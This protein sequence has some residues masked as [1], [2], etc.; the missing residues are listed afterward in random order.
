M[1]AS[2]DI[3]AIALILGC[4][5][6]SHIE[7]VSHHRQ[8]AEG[9]AFVIRRSGVKTSAHGLMMWLWVYCES[10]R[11]Q[12]CMMNF[13][14]QGQRQQMRDASQRECLKQRHIRPPWAGENSIAKHGRVRAV[15]VRD[16]W[17]HLL[18]ER[19]WFQW[20][21]TL[22]QRLTLLLELTNITLAWP[23]RISSVPAYMT[24]KRTWKK[25]RWI[26]GFIGWYSSFLS[27]RDINKSQEL[28]CF[29]FCLRWHINT[30][31]P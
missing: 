13:K 30:Q 24:H 3:F 12:V 21:W 6:L 17:T 5:S 11:C 26:L 7:V 4:C 23:R 16:C 2:V 9:I 1:L 31:L 29:T 27:Q 15:P 10:L 19:H 18:Q 8:M 20:W 25:R 28:V 22:E 14:V